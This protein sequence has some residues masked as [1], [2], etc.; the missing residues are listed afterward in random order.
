VIKRYHEVDW[1]ASD[2]EHEAL[3]AEMQRRKL[4]F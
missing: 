2:P 4:D 3:V 1:I